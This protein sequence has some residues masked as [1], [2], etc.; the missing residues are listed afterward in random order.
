M[1]KIVV[2]SILFMNACTNSKQDAPS[3]AACENFRIGAFAYRM[4]GDSVVYHAERNESIQK[5]KE[6]GTSNISMYK[7]NWIS[8]CSY[9]LVYEGKYYADRDTTIK[10]EEGL[11]IRVN[12]LEMKADSMI[13]EIKIPGMEKELRGSMFKVK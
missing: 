10:N 12:L 7:V 6:P 1:K 5:E 13:F 8:P 9:D 2:A 3:E 11:N 4:E